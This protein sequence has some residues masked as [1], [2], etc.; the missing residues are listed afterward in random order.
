M[1]LLLVLSDTVCVCVCLIHC[2]WLWLTVW[3]SCVC[4]CV[5]HQ[6]WDK[7][8]LQT[9]WIGC[10]TS[11]SLVSETDILLQ[12][13]IFYQFYSVY[14]VVARSNGLVI[15][16]NIFKNTLYIYMY[17]YFRRFARSVTWGLRV[18]GNV[19]FVNGLCGSRRC[20]CW[21]LLLSTYVELFVYHLVA[22]V[23]KFFW[24]Q[25]NF[26]GSVFANSHTDSFSFMN[27]NFYLST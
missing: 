7:V 10:C 26:V 11:L 17:C 21:N 20:I 24:N 6:Q 8:L 9:I 1:F 25:S 22:F 4:L 18:E 27:S 23:C 2:S 12:S 13:F 19:F 5:C 3:M 15:Y 14:R 16:Y